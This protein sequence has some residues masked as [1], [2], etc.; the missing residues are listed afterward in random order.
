MKP[1]VLKPRQTEATPRVPFREMVVATL[2]NLFPC[3][4]PAQ[5]AA[6]RQGKPVPPSPDWV[7][8][9]TGTPIAEYLKR[10]ATQAVPPRGLLA[11]MAPAMPQAAPR[12]PFPLVSA[13]LP[14]FGPPERLRLTRKAITQFL[15][16]TYPRKQL[17]LVN[18]TGKPVLPTSHPLVKEVAV[19]EASLGALRNAGIRAADGEWVMP[20]DD[21]DYYHPYRMVYQ[22][23]YRRPGH[24][25][26][27]ASQIRV[28]VTRVMKGEGNVTAFVHRQDGGIPSTIIHPRL[29]D[30]RLYPDDSLGEDV[31]FWAKHWGVRTVVAA[32]TEFPA[33]GVS[34]AVF[35]EHSLSTADQFM[36]E[37]SRPEA[38]GMLELDPPA[39]AYLRGVLE[40]FGFQV[41]PAA[42][43]KP[44]PVPA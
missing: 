14:H 7:V 3:L 27:L 29:P 30:G 18:A 33:S 8:P 1:T 43:E 44:S 37:F 23:A 40:F 26:L 15:Y 35:H 12:D 41:R 11:P 36:A 9:G 17:V 16:Q 19:R 31:A 10:T 28:D 42:W 25:V 34:V 20:W 24:A 39:A 5:V 13:V 32:N 38:A 22:M 21:D 2:D 6:L 4:S